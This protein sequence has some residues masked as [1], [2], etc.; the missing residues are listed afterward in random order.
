MPFRLPGFLYNIAPFLYIIAG[1][2]AGLILKTNLAVISGTLLALV[3]ILILALRF[4]AQRKTTSFR[5]K[6]TILLKTQEKELN[7]LLLRLRW[8]KSYESGNPL[9]D[10]QHRKIHELGSELVNKAIKQID[11]ESILEIQL[12]FDKMTKL[13]AEHFKDEESLISKIN[14][15]GYQKHKDSH[16][17]LLAKC[18][19]ISRK[20][21]KGHLPTKEILQFIVTDL[22]A[23]H[24]RK[25]DIV[26]FEWIR[27]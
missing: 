25:E 27:E 2:C 15:P 10:E 19:V 18:E 24:L 22:I 7:D 4:V 1:L 6:K 12:L 20:F 21:S 9:I 14:H 8:R 16:R 17:S 26:F 3:G 5:P 23:D 11:R 13:M